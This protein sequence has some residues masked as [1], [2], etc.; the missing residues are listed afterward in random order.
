MDETWR[1]AQKANQSITAR[2]ERRS[3]AHA[4]V[5]EHRRDLL[6]AEFPCVPVRKL[7]ARTLRLLRKFLEVS[8]GCS[9]M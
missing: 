8:V 9:Q 3:P 7:Q 2:L 1:S 4:A 5:T 6:L